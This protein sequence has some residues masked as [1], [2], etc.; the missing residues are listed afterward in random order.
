MTRQTLTRLF[1]IG[2]IFLSA[3]KKD[4]DPPKDPQE[5]VPQYQLKSIN[6]SNGLTGNFVYN[7]KT[8]QY[9]DYTFQNVSGRTIHGFTG[10][11]ITEM[12]DDRSQYRNVF[13]YDS[14][15][16]VTKMRNIEWYDLQQTKYELVFHYNSANRIDTM[17][18]FSFNEAGMKPRW[19]S[20]Y[21]YNSAG[22]LVKVIT[23]YDKTIITHTIDAYSPLV[24]FEAYHYIE[25]TLNENFTIY[26][27]GIMMQLQK[28]HKLPAKVT[29]VVQTGTEPS[30]VDKVE[31]DVFM[32][33][34]YRI[35]KVN[36]AI[37]YPEMGYVNKL[38][39]VYSYF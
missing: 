18:Y 4:N 12:Y 29:R 9:I 8:L 35:E 32:V 38:E 13:E 6:W 39:A 16:R 36:S 3:C 17:R 27:L 10:N 15:G 31:E 2:L 21:E 19:V 14:D 37:S 20:G 24:S 1:L 26:N 7:D 25:P 22:D 34:N 28:A 33:E 5:N 30:Y 23:K 11:A